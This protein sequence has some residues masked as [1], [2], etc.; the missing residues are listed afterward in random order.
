M[1]YPSGGTVTLM[2]DEKPSIEVELNSDG[3]TAA[4]LP[5][6]IPGGFI[7]PPAAFG[8]HSGLPKP[9]DVSWGDWTMRPGKP[10]S[11][12][13]KRLAE[14]IAQGKK[15]PEI[16]EILGMHH[17]RVSV[18]RTN[19]QI[20]QEADRYRDRLFSATVQEQLLSLAPDALST[21][22]EV[23]R[24]DDEK[25]STRADTAR[26]LLEKLTGKARQEVGVD[27]GASLLELLK[28]LDDMKVSGKTQEERDVLE[29]AAGG[30]VAPSEDS[31]MD[32]WV[33]GNIP[34]V[35]NEKSEGEKSE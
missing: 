1:S 14:L 11:S 18:L 29:I 13:H 4:P 31:W 25:L 7:N 30:A 23:L 35:E 6:P 21:I 10:L 34:G 19:T 26:W 3:A 9:E 15:N 8:H 22:E 5:E 33:A 12:R 28:K 17:V 16:A 20:I 27:A 32:D 2:T 24:S